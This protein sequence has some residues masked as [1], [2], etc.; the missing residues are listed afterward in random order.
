[1]GL[2]LCPVCRKGH[3]EAAE[4]VRVFEPHGKRVEVEAADLG[5]QC[6]R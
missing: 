6:L 1:M 2:G 3:L 5:L 4:R